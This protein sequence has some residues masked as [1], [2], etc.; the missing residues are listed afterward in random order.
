[1][2]VMADCALDAGMAAAWE[3]QEIINSWGIG[4]FTSLVVDGTGNPI[5]SYYDG[6]YRDF[7]LATLTKPVYLPVIQKVP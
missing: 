6:D 4:Q 5:I 2:G 1:M 7:K 3:L